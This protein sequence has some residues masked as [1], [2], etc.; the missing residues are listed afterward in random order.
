MIGK[1]YI[2]FLAEGA[3]RE[4]L[5]EPMHDRS[6]LAWE[7][8]SRQKCGSAHGAFISGTNAQGGDG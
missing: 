6:Y 5:T 3:A 7:P 8:F 2:L 4:T 1:G